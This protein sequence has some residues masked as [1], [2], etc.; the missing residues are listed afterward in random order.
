M[1]FAGADWPLRSW[2]ASV[3]HLRA[4]NEKN[5]CVKS[6]IPTIFQ[7]IERDKLNFS[8]AVLLKKYSWSKD[9][10]ECLSVVHSK[11][12]TK[13]F[14][15]ITITIT[16]ILKTVWKWVYLLTD[17]KWDVALLSAFPH[18]RAETR[19]LFLCVLRLINY[20]IKTAHGFCLLWREYY[21]I[22]FVT[23]CQ[24]TEPA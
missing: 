5:P 4:A 11:I 3:I 2:I 23:W 14:W 1:L 21:T 6:L 7:Y 22:P 12:N 20:C 19:L 16:H 15:L 24:A 18:N 13:D 8:K 9:S 10:Q 17:I